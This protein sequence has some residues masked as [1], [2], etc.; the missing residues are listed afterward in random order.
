MNSTRTFTATVAMVA[1]L[2]GSVA[3]AP[4][5]SAKGSDGVRASGSCSAGANWKIK[6]KHDDGRIEVELEVDSNK[7]GQTWAV[8]IKDNGVLVF[9]G[10]RVTKAPSGSFSIEKRVTNRAGTDSFVGVAKN[11][12]SGEKCTARVSL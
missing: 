5:A 4:A 9:S 3:L 2:T 6:A 12:K 8:T 10:D 11:T 7:V 1:L